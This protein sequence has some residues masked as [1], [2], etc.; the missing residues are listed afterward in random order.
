MWW[1]GRYA[2]G[3]AGGT[4]AC[5]AW[6]RVQGSEGEGPERSFDEGSGGGLVAA[7]GPTAG[8][9]G[10]G[11]SQ[12][13]LVVSVRLPQGRVMWQHAVAQASVPALEG[14]V[15]MLLLLLDRSG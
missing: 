3:P 4:L 5:G 9:S 12:Q 1:A 2:A 7:L 8:G 13:H 15:R 11:I 14:C 10:I 6:G